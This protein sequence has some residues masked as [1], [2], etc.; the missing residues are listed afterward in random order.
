LSGILYKRFQPAKQIPGEKVVAAPQKKLEPDRFEAA[1][2]NTDRR[3]K[4][5]EKRI[6]EGRA[7]H[8]GIKAE[9][10]PYEDRLQDLKE[11]TSNA[12]KDVALA[13][14]PAALAE[15]AYKEVIAKMIKEPFAKLPE[16]AKEQ[17]RALARQKLN[18]GELQAV[19]RLRQETATLLAE[20]VKLHEADLQPARARLANANREMLALNEQLSSLQAEKAAL[21]NLLQ[22]QPR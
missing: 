20:E 15:A 12:Q 1:L 5:I 10:K 17:V 2:A 11:K 19:L 7:W 18:L 8:A 9:N 6:A 3:I 16:S 13:A 4:Y 21:V 14:A 22:K